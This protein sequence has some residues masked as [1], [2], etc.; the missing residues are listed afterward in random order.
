MRGAKP[1]TE[2]DLDQISSLLE[3]KHPKPARILTVFSPL[4]VDYLGLTDFSGPAA[5]LVKLLR[6]RHREEAPVAPLRGNSPPWNRDP[7]QGEDVI[8]LT[9][10][11]GM[12][13][14]PVDLLF[15][16]SFLF[17]ICPF[18]FLALGPEL[19][20]S[21]ALLGD[22]LSLSMSWPAAELGSGD[23]H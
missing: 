9:S 19:F 11:D 21:L 6:C 20:F 12:L 4:R 18:P 2:E 5:L 15:S 8:G 10:L 3:K 16:L 1:G 7:S 14:T 22:G 17:S 13:T 23:P